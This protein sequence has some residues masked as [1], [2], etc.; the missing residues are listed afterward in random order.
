M[1]SVKRG[2]LSIRRHWF[3]TF[4]WFCIIL[5]L[6]TAVATE[7]SIRKAV[8][9]TDEDLRARLP[10]IASIH[11]DQ[12]TLNDPNLAGKVFEGRGAT[13]IRTHSRSRSVI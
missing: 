12:A 11:L 5:L 7:I 1:T 3:R 10:A 8:I 6:T 2:M 13:H 9:N 4:L